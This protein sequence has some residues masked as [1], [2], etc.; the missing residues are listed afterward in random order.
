MD[1]YPQYNCWEI[2]NC[3]NPECP[4]RLDPQTP[5]WEIA[6]R[7]ESFRSVFNIC[8]DCIVYILKENANVLEKKEL[9]LIIRQRGLLK[10]L[11]DD[12]KVCV[13]KCAA[14]G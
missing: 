9:F 10:N 6:R 8:R 2:M 5:C 13:L 1:F 14:H 4:A 3:D 7:Y 11:R 12:Q